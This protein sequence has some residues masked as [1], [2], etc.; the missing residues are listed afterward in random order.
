M[1]ILIKHPSFDAPPKT[2]KASQSASYTELLNSSPPSI[3]S[4][5]TLSS[6]TIV[7]RLKKINTAIIARATSQILQLILA[8][9]R[10]TYNLNSHK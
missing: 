1:P 3:K 2:V 10:I 4:S 9:S 5:Y 8:F 7:I 6:S